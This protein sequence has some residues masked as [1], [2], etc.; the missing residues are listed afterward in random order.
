MALATVAPTLFVIAAPE[1]PLAVPTVAPMEA[2][3]EAP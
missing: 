1:L 3:E 2:P